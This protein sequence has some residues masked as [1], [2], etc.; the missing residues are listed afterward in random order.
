VVHGD[1]Y[2]SSKIQP[3]AP[4]AANTTKMQTRASEFVRRRK[5]CAI[6]FTVEASLEYAT[7]VVAP[8]L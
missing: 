4:V 3:P 1:Q 8:W 6:K 2:T 7:E 5:I